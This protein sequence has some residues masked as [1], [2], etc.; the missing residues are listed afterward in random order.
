ME[1][2]TCSKLH[3]TNRYHYQEQGWL[4]NL[5]SP[6]QN[7]NRGGGVLLKQ[8]LR[9]ARQQQQSSEPSM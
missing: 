5:Q 8:L 7:K 3:V 6:V 2:L 4:R 1:G 9:I